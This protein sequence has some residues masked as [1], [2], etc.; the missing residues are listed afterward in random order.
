MSHPEASH[1]FIQGELITPLLDYETLLLINFALFLI[2]AHALITHYR[3][4]I[5]SKGVKGE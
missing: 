2:S 5:L 4:V 1:V 3:R